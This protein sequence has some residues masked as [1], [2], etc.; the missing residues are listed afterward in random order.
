MSDE[1]I[2]LTC[3][4]Y[5]LGYPQS[6]LTRPREAKDVFS[7]GAFIES[8]ISIYPNSISTRTTFI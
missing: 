3:F 7:N 5:F 1:S 4:G 6:H 2:M 8:A